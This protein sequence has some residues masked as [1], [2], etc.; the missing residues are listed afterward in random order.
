MEYEEFVERG[1]KPRITNNEKK[2]YEVTNLSSFIAS[3]R[4]VSKDPPKVYVDFGC[5]VV[6]SYDYD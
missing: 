3:L 1:E 4:C 2:H 5:G 6:R